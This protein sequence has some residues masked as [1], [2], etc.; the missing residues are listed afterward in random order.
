MIFWVTMPFRP[1]RRSLGKGLGE[2]GIEPGA[3]P[4]PWDGRKHQGT[5][6]IQRTAYDVSPADARC[7]SLGGAPTKGDD[8]MRGKNSP[9]SRFG[10]QL[11]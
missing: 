9:R 4:G 6:R 2:A 3:Y 8:A 11:P 5:P 7:E 10:L 1:R